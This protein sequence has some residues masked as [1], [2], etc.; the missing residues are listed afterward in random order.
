MEPLT[1]ASAFATIV[2][3]LCN[4]KAER[5]SV[6]PTSEDFTRWLDEHGFAEIALQS[7]RSASLLLSIDQLLREDVTVLVEKVAVLDRS[8][9]SLASTM[10]VLAPIAEAVRPNE[11]LSEQAVSILVFMEEKQA[12]TIGTSYTHSSPY[13]SLYTFPR[14]GSPDCREPRFL[15]DDLQSLVELGLLRPESETQSG[16]TYGITREASRLVRSMGE[17]QLEPSED[18]SESAQER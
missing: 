10:G 11:R 12:T 7:K 4:F 16:R 14:A 3:L 2:G 17:R 8:L 5:K 13:P 1:T 9:A 15:E 18:E 6:T